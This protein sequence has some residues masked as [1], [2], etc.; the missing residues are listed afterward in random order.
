MGIVLAVAAQDDVLREILCG[1]GHYA[2]TVIVEQ[3]QQRG[4]P[5][6]S[7]RGCQATKL[8]DVRYLFL[9]LCVYYTSQMLDLIATL[10]ALYKSII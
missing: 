6:E 5:C 10:A 4:H 9:I 1:P 7:S 2:N 3:R 8:G